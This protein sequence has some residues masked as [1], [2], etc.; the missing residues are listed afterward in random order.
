[1]EKSRS[2]DAEGILMSQKRYHPLAIAQF[3]VLSYYMFRDTQDS[4]YYW[5]CV[6]QIKYFKDTTRVHSLFDGKGIGLP[7]NYNF[8]DMK[9]P[10]YSGM[11]QGYA[12]S[13]LLRYHELTKDDEALP[14]IKKIAFVLLQKQEDGGTISKTKEGYTWIEEYPNSKRSPA[15]L[16]GYI[17]GLIGLKEYTDFFPKDTLAQRILKETYYGLTNSLEYYDA[18]NK[19]YYNRTN[20]EL[21]NKYLRY[22]IYEMKHLYEIFQDEIFDKQRRIWSAQAFN[23][24]I[25]GN[26]DA[27]KYPNHTISAPVEKIRDGRY[28]KNIVNDGM[29]VAQSDTLNFQL[30]TSQKDLDKYLKKKRLKKRKKNTGDLFYSFNANAAKSFNYFEI[31]YPNSDAEIN[32]LNVNGKRAVPVKFMHD[33]DSLKMAVSV[34]DQDI[35]DL[36]LHF[37]KGAVSDTSK[38]RIRFYNT[39]SFKPPHFAHWKSKP[40]KLK[41]GKSYSHTLQTFNSAK[42]VIFYKHAPSQGELKN[43][44]WMAKNT[45]E[46][47]FTPEADGAYEFMVV[48]DYTCPLSMMNEFEL[49]EL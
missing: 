7:Y 29:L 34:A 21:T 37:K 28:G 2:V 41:Q 38:I 36:V 5:K 19:S 32:V 44:K 17:N 27:F 16:N 31:D 22:Q 43:T 10:W 9:N 33:S 47:V 4:V 24:A 13:Y 26:T 18:P 6:N 35:N 48:F 15:V 30:L 25:K 11:T 14:L 39:N 12:I 23:K 8:W 42:A 49:K 45:V 1:M 40:M 46:D 20:R 3:G